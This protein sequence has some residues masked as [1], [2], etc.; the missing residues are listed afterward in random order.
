M[1]IRSVLILLTLLVAACNN[2][3]TMVEDAPHES[4]GSEEKNVAEAPFVDGQ[5]ILRFQDGVGR[6]QVIGIVTRNG[7][8]VLRYEIGSTG[9]MLIE[10]QS[11][12]TVFDAVRIYSDLPE[13]E[14]AEPNYIREERGDN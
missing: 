10:I 4:V 12:Q 5:L 7:D 2:Q 3:G 14:Y 9:A 1:R 6:D 11:G 13:V 8:A